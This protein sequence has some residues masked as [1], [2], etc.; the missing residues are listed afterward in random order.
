MNRPQL[1]PDDSLESDAVW[2]LLDQAAPV[3]PRPSFADDVVRMAKLL[4]ADE[5]WWKKFFAPA[6]V[7]GLAG[8]AAAVALAFILLPDRTP[9]APTIA[10]HEPENSA[11]ADP[12]ADIQDFAETE[13]LIAAA[14]HLDHFSDQE[15]AGLIGF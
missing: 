13:T 10:S 15:I 4:P 3:R 2:K 7:A 8:L 11:H 9:S 14:D 12:F 1:P 6:P 5:P